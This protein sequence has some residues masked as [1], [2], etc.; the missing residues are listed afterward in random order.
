MTT[1]LPAVVDAAAA[2]DRAAWDVLV[3]RYGRLVWAIARGFRLGDADAADVSQAVWLRLVEN[4][5]GIRD[6]G[7]LASWLGTTTRRE[8]LAVLRR[9]SDVPLS[10]LDDTDAGDEPPPWHGVL[11][12]ERDR[13]LWRAF[14]RLP[15][16]CQ[17]LLRL[18]VIEP[19]GY[20]AAA[21]ALDVPIGS[22]GPTRAR[23]LH[24][25]RAELRTAD[26]DE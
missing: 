4:L 19:A 7:A 11:A 15:H 8:A 6:P 12:E 22:L 20:S 25:L 10:D 2:G 5:D 14:D 23:C 1:D 18:L 3:E 26:G 21:A 16:R 17:R 24:A 13:E 9:R